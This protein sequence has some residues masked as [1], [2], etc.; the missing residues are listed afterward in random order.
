MPNT[1]GLYTIKEAAAILNLGYLQTRIYL[2][3]PQSIGTTP[4]GRKCLLYS[5]DRINEIQD[6][7]K[8]V[9]AE[10]ELNKGKVKCYHCGK[11]VPHYDLTSGVCSE[12]QAIKLVKNFACHGDY[13]NGKLDRHR[14]ICLY[15]AIKSLVKKP[16]AKQAIQM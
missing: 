10:R 6:R 15:N 2:G 7:R 12:C 9:L 1:D 4:K 14:L 13:I 11:R 5:I 16:K 8:V 3:D